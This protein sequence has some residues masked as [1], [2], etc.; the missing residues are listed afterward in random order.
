M[1]QPSRPSTCSAA[2]L[3]GPPPATPSPADPADGEVPP[4]VA[5]LGPEGLEELDLPDGA[6]RDWLVQRVFDPDG[7]GADFAYTMGLDRYGLPELHL[8]A[9]PTLGDDPGADWML[10]GTD[11]QSLLNRAAAHLL[12][13]RLGPGAEWT[14]RFDGGLTSAR[15]R[16]GMPVPAEYLDAYRLD[17]RHPVLPLAFSLHRPEPGPPGPLDG[18][19]AQQVDRWTRRLR[20]Q[21]DHLRAATLAA[22]QRVPIVPA[23]WRLPPAAALGDPVE[24][25]PG[26]PFG[27]LHALVTA[28]AT[29]LLV[30][31]PHTLAEFMLRIGAA[32]AVGVTPGAARAVLLAACRPVGREQAVARAL[33]SA[34]PL[35]EEI[36]GRAR[37][38]RRWREACVV[39]GGPAGG[40]M[41]RNHEA[42]CREEALP[43]VGVTL[44]VEVLAD[45]LSD[46][47]LAL[48]RGPWSWAV[49]SGGG[50]PDVPW[51]AP[52][53]LV[54]RVDRLLAGWDPARAEALVA[55]F[56]DG[57]RAAF[58]A[59]ADRLAGC[60]TVG[61][62]SPPAGH[63]LLP[64]RARDRLEPTEA[65]LCEHLA[66]TLVAALAFRDRLPDGGWEAVA[67]L[68]GDPADLC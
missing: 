32:A 14:E 46:Q 45:V 40:R 61:P 9:R 51:Q 29:Q 34:E 21:T 56:R 52:A 11:Q 6:Q 64:D 23:P 4:A 47:H 33:D 7:G 41:Q 39:L 66:R 65:L 16:V 25:D 63:R 42:G 13:A 48:A 37:V 1:P 35:L 8:W 12:R 67:G 57:D 54:D 2:G 60:C 44:A 10:S 49:H 15:F 68:F 36:T 18:R 17:A 26:Q 20:A 28:R 59:A 24:V 55:R 22:G 38:T 62:G 31:D 19:T 30:A 5:D 53:S 27:P 58:A 43:W 50:A 3:A